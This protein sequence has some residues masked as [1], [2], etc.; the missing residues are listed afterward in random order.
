MAEENKT[1]ID[2]V[3]D[4]MPGADPV[5]AEDKEG[6]KVDLNFAEVEPVEDETEEVLFV[7]NQ[8]EFEDDY[9]VD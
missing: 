6:F 4:T 5:S 1:N 9:E 7:I 8:S 3:N 2:V